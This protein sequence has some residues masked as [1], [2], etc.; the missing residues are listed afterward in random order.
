MGSARRIGRRHNFYS[1]SKRILAQTLA[2]DLAE[3]VF[4]S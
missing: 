2:D 4:G 3:I 1:V